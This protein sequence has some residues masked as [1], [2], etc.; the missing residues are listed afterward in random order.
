MLRTAAAL[1]ALGINSNSPLSDTTGLSHQRSLQ[2]QRAPIRSARR[3]GDQGEPQIFP[4]VFLLSREALF[5][6]TAPDSSIFTTCFSRQSRSSITSTD[7][8]GSVTTVVLFSPQPVAFFRTA[9]LEARAFWVG[10]GGKCLL[11]GCGHI[12]STSYSNLTIPWL[13]EP[14]IGWI[15][16]AWSN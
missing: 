4:E 5:T 11:R 16:I 14:G 6:T 10:F 3:R 15:S 9:L 1:A 8:L 12:C 2:R 7:R 13:G